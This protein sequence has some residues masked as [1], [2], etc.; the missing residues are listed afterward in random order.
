MSFNSFFSKNTRTYKYMFIS[1]RKH[2][3]VFLIK[4]QIKNYFAYW[5]KRFSKK[6]LTLTLYAVQT[7]H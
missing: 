2:N 6:V 5:R 4:M 7:Y 1:S 3:F